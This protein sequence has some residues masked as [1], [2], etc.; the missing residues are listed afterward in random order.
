MQFLIGQIKQAWYALC[1]WRNGATPTN[2]EFDQMRS[3]S[4]SAQ[5]AAV[6]SSYLEQVPHGVA[7]LIRAAKD[8][9]P[10]MAGGAADRDA[11]HEPCP[12]LG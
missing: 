12:E 8:L 2:D 10:E 9:H 4:I 5:L 11:R 3:W 1:L 7:A 6:P